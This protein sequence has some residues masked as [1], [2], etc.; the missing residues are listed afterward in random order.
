MKLKIIAILAIL[1]NSVFAQNYHDTQGKLEISG[2]GQATF[3]LPIAMPPSINN[4]GPKIDVNY[5][6]G[7]LSGIAGQGWN[8][9][10]ISK[11]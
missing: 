4:Y 9:N 2:S 11:Q 8:I 7:Q 3:N 10:G 5:A 1:A 6:S